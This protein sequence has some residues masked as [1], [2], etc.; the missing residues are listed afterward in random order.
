M[1]AKTFKIQVQDNHPERIPQ[2]PDS[3]LAM[4]EVVD[5]GKPQ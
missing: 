1:S 5:H 4:A 3:I 2:A